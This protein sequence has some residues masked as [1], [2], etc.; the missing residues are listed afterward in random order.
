MVTVSMSQL[1]RTGN[2]HVNTLL[3]KNYILRKIA[4]SMGKL[5]DIIRDAREGRGL[6]QPQLATALGLKR[7]VSIS[8]WETSEAPIPWHHFQ[9]LIDV[10]G[11]PKDKFIETARRE[12]PAAVKA[13]EKYLGAS[14]QKTVSPIPVLPRG[15]RSVPVINHS[16]CGKWR[17]FTDLDFPA[18][19]SDRH[20]LAPTN[21]QHAFYVIAA[22]DSMIGG[23][24]EDGDLLLI[25]PSKR[26]D[27]G[28][29]VL[30][31]VADK[32]CTV[33]KFFRHDGHVELRPMNDQ[34]KSLIVKNDPSLRVY[35]VT[36]IVKQV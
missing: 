3:T 27:D 35:R 10:L 16:A 30:A 24:I 12:I 5:G 23:K 21:D 7:P 1:Y 32:G 28:D 13:F 36:R 8:R 15:M 17:D 14:A 33:K 4:Q 31:K 29:I 25:E 22:G 18:G 34:H 11:L 26:V 2:V 6:T 9:G 20:E 19:H